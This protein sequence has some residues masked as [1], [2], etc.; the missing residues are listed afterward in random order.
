MDTTMLYQK[1]QLKRKL[2][3]P[4]LY[5]IFQNTFPQDYQTMGELHDFWELVYVSKGQ[6][7]IAAGEDIFALKTGELFFHKPGEYKSPPT[8]AI[9]NRM[10]TFHRL[11]KK[12]S[13]FE[14]KLQFR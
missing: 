11:A 12:G 14:R 6:A 2:A 7:E 9:A 10:L 1:I 4:H 5:T 8:W 13:P 3:V